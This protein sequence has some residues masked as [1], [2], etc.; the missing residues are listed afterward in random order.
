[1]NRSTNLVRL[2]G[3]VCPSCREIKKRKRVEEVIGK[4]KREENNS[5]VVRSSYQSEEWVLAG[6]AHK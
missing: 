2:V 3:G 1:M 5:R 6:L 4:K